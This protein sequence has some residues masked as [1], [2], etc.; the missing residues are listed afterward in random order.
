MVSNGFPNVTTSGQRYN[1]GEKPSVILY[2]YINLHAGR[3]RCVQIFLKTTILF[4][5]LGVPDYC[6]LKKNLNAS[7]LS[8]PQSGGNSHIR[9]IGC[10]PE[11]N[12]LHGDQSRSWSASQ[13]KENKKRKS[14]STPAPPPPRCSFGENSS[15]VFFFKWFGGGSLPDVIML[16]SF[17]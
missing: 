15:H 5:C 3:F 8:I 4:I 2:T 6:C 7:R 9:R 17:D 16:T 11:R 14:G 1:I 10:Q 12:T 13:G